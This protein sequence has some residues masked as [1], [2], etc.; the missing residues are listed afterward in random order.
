MRYHISQTRK[1]LVRVNF[2]G[3]VIALEA[4]EH[5]GPV[6][7]V[8][9]K[10][11]VS[12]HEGSVTVRADSAGDAVWRVAQATVRAVAELTDSPLD[13]EIKAGEIKQTHDDNLIQPTSNPSEGA[14]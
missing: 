14:K 13:G 2:P 7:E 5:G 3:R 4:S 6:W 11:I 8:G 12:E 10:D 1:G 9:V